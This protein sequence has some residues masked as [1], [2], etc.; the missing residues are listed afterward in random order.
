MKSSL[1]FNQTSAESLSTCKSFIVGKYP[2]ARYPYFANVS[3]KFI[4]GAVELCMA[5]TSHTN[6][7]DICIRLFW[8]TLHPLWVKPGYRILFVHSHQ[9]L[10]PHHSLKWESYPRWDR[11]HFFQPWHFFDLPI[12][13]FYRPFVSHMAA[14]LSHLWLASFIF[15]SS[16]KCFLFTCFISTLKYAYA[17]PSKI[18]IVPHLC[19]SPARWATK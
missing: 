5:A 16:A 8:K 1:T 4:S 13:T 12:Q 14:P 6:V 19:K 10:M 15:L 9:R 2:P 7:I 11:T 17:L 3:C 18:G